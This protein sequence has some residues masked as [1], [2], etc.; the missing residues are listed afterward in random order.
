[1]TAEERE[2]EFKETVQE[3]STAIVLVDAE[4][5]SSFQEALKIIDGLLSDPFAQE[6]TAVLDLLS[7]IQTKVSESIIDSD[8]FPERLVEI[9]ADLKRILSGDPIEAEEVSEETSQQEGEPE[10]V[11]EA[12]EESGGGEETKP[13]TGIEADRDLYDDFLMEADES[14]ESIEVKILSLEEDPSNLDVVNEIFRPFHTI[15]GVSGFLNLNLINRLTHAVEDLLDKAR[16]GDIKIGPR[17]IEATL[18]AVDLLKKLLES[19]RIRLEGGT[20]EDLSGE[21]ADFLAMLKGDGEASEAEPEEASEPAETAEP[22]ATTEAPEVVEQEEEESGPVCEKVAKPR[23]APEPV[24]QNSKPKGAA[25]KA[26]SSKGQTTIKVDMEKLDDLVNMVGELVIAQAL[27][28]QHPGIQSMKDRVLSKSFGLLSRITSELRNTTMSLRMVPLQQ[29]FRKMIR[30]VRDLS[31]KSGK[32]INLVMHGEETEIDRNM[33]DA[34]YEPLVHLVRNAVDHGIDPVEERRATGKSETGTIT[35]HA[36]H[37]GGNVVIEIR[38]DGRGLSREKILKKAIERGIVSPDEVLADHEIDQLIFRAGFSTADTVTD[39]S[40]RGVGMDIVRKTIEGLRGKI[41]I[42]SV[43][44]KG[45]TFIM[46]LPITLAII[47]G[48]IVRVGE[49]RYVLPTVNIRETIRPREEDCFTLVG[50]GEM[51]RIRGNLLPVIRLHELFTVQTER[52][53]IWEGLMV[54]VEMNGENRCLLVDEVLEKQEVVIKS[55]G[56][57][58]SHP[59][60]VAGGSILGDGRVCLI[61]DL[62]G[63]FRLQLKG[64]SKGDMQLAA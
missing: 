45:S 58:W 1:M 34:V 28:Q 21:T 61:L 20:A 29:T 9:E 57:G 30:L 51:V 2:V 26:T 15:K 38:D 33:V 22:V 7:G 19:V 54:V 13:L 53:E 47:D 42:Q 36:Y 32:S 12:K 11:E 48:M 8:S 52:S 43:P 44:G 10:A 4:D 56:K 39:V 17:E 14:L 62:D 63:I 27:V 49:E 6:N 55:L 16:K 59:E 18:E 31:R 46:K 40:G 3:L 25:P 5:P 23:T 60:G 24:A 41:E 50:K 64:V 37:K 35:L